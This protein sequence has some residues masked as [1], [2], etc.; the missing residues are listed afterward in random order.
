MSR[1][2][3]TAETRASADVYDEAVHVKLLERDSVRRARLAG[4]STNP[5]ALVVDGA[6]VY[7]A[8][9]RSSSSGLVL[10][11]TKSELEPTSTAHMG[12]VVAG[13][14]GAARGLW[15]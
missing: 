3:S 8:L 9:A 4:R 1:F 15:D 2:S 5:A 7:D 6:D 13:D 11:V 14:S 10:K 12:G